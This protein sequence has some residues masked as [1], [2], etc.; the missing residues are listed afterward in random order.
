MS[1]WRET[2]STLPPAKRWG[3][4]ASILLGLAG[5][6]GLLW[7]AHT[8][9]SAE[10][11]VAGGGLT[12]G[13]I[14]SPRFINPLLATSDTD[15]DLTTLIY[16]GLLRINEAGQLIP[17]LAESFET[18]ENGLSYTFTLKEGL[19]WH[20][21]QPL[22]AEDVV[23]TAETA[24]DPLLKSPKRAGWE[25]VTAEALDERTVTFQLSQPYPSFLENNATAGILPKHIWSQLDL[26]TFPLSQFNIESVGSGPY[27]IKKIKKNNLGIPQYYDLAPFARFALGEPKIQHLR[28]K[29][30]P[31]ESELLAAYRRGE[32]ESL[33]AASAAETKTL[34]EGGARVVAR[35]LPRIFAVF[36][37]QN[38]A[39]IFAHQEVRQALDLALNKQAIIDQVLQGY[40]V[41]AEGPLPPTSLGFTLLPDGQDPAA[42]TAAVELNHLDAAR[43]LL[44]EAGWTKNAET[45]RWEKKTRS[46]T[47]S[48]TLAIATAETPELKEAA[49]L[50][51]EMWEELGAEVEL[52]I[53]EIGDL[54]QNVIRPRQYEALFFGEILNRHPDPFV[55]WHSSQRL[56][57]GLN[58]ALY[59]NISADKLLEEARGATEERKVE[60]YGQF[61]EEVRADAAAAFVYV[62]HF[63]YILPTEIKNPAWPPINTPADRFLNIHHWYRNT[64][65]VWKIFDQNKQNNQTN[66][67]AHENNET[68]S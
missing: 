17:D 6:I 1:T 68:Q 20:D 50:I 16:S 66:P 24:Q 65:R 4:L 30:Y 63:L 21:G 52:K 14:G 42:E 33:A 60:L 67:P 45:S 3:L 9:W 10:V 57:P 43:A 37:N 7:L 26:E 44:E 58:I 15:R 55:F 28:I 27:Q 46:E 25:G 56:D 54:N 38:R 23:F 31:S 61:Q 53:F 49:T 29:F 8:S 59:A 13:V 64:A 32:I 34:A 35:P 47:L 40:G 5:L 51:K 19:T 36:F 11:P 39:P 62:P 22:R 2:L 18:G 41:V 48:L 12:E